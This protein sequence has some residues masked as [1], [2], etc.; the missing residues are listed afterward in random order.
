MSESCPGEFGIA[1][2]FYGHSITV[3]QRSPKPS[4]WVRILVPVRRAG[5]DPA[6]E[7]KRGR[8]GRRLKIKKNEQDHDVF[9]GIVQRVTGKSDLA[10]LAAIAAVDCDRAGG[11]FADHPGCLGDGY[12]IQFDPAFC[13][14]LV[15]RLKFYI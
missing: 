1:F 4:V 9:P 13:I 8:V 7:I 5:G 6:V 3:V 10:Y 11:N 2:S 12:G 15:R 14:F